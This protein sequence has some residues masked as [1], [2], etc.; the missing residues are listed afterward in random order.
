MSV[1]LQ[2]DQRLCSFVLPAQTVPFKWI[3]QAK[4]HAISNYNNNN[5]NNNYYYYYCHGDWHKFYGG[6][7]LDHGLLGYDTV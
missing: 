3:C 2:Y 7:N 4:Q 6:E 5:N 1:G